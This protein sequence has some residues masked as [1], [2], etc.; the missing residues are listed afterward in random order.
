M[1]PKIYKKNYENTVFVSASPEVVFAFANDHQNFSAHMNESSFMM[2]GSKMET[3]VDE[4]G[5]KQLGSHI[6]MKGNV[7]GLKLFLDEVVVEYEPPFKKSWETVGNINLVVIDHYK[8]GFNVVPEGKGSQFNV[9]INYNPPKS[10]IAR[11][12]GILFGDVYAQWCVNQMTSG[13]KEHFK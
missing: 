6:K 12:L 10:F 9:F 1:E 11:I 2:G 5:G 7:L 3:I 13:V 8:L 4:G